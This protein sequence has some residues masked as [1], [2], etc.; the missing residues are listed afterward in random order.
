M[1]KEGV[2]GFYRGVW[3]STLQIMPYM[4]IMFQ[5]QQF[6]S[7]FMKNIRSDLKKKYFWSGFDEFVS[8][9][10]AGIVSKTAVMPFDV[11]R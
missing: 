2:R 10:M 5:T 8:G 9:G 6:F 3:P 7:S 11:I 1:E 4:G